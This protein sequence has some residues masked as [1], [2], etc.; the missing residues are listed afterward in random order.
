MTALSL[1]LMKLGWKVLVIDAD[2]EAPSLDLI[3][4]KTLRL[5][6]SLLGLYLGEQISAIN[7][8]SKFSGGGLIDILGAK[9]SVTQKKI[10]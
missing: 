6:N 3:Y 5:E 8:D 9:P 4:N 2:F 1:S 10:R 7:Y